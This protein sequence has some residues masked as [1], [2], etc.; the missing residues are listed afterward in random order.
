MRYKFVFYFVLISFFI[1]L[2]P[3][4]FYYFDEPETLSLDILDKMIAGNYKDIMPSQNKNENEFDA[5]VREFNHEFSREIEKELGLEWGGH[6]TEGYREV[7][8]LGVQLYASRPATLPEARAI[9]L[10][11]IE[12]YRQKIAQ[13]ERVKPFIKE[14]SIQ[15]QDVKMTITFNN[16]DCIYLEGEI[17]QISNH[18]S[19]SQLLYDAKSAFMEEDPVS[20]EENLEEAIKL[21]AASPVSNL[22]TH[23]ASDEEKVLKQAIYH[24]Y[25]EIAGTAKLMPY[26]VT[27]KKVEG[28][29]TFCCDMTAYFPVTQEKARELI[30]FA[31]KRMLHAINGSDQLKSYLGAFPLESDR[32]KLRISFVDKRNNPYSD[33]SLDSVVLESNKI[34]YYQYKTFKKLDYET[35]DKFLIGV[36][37][38]PEVLAASMGP[39]KFIPIEGDL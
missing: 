1:T 6:S 17:Y 18:F 28:V 32:L 16:P 20:S 14:R 31:T 19:D 3:Q 2:L 11:L 25:E 34:Y 27:E 5:K 9:I 12:D 30:L 10:F 33:V 21:N 13:D 37:S 36:E 22:A 4:L 35:E 7:P 38:Y 29:S 8:L 15:S 26:A 23:A 39:L 24:F